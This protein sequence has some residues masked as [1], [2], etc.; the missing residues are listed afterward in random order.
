MKSAHVVIEGV[1]QGVNYRA[2]TQRAAAELELTGWVR[3]RLDGTVEALFCGE[4]ELVDRMVARCWEGPAPARVTN[5][6]LLPFS[7]EAPPPPFEVL[8]TV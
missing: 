5:V 4:T 2:W 3:N 1:V 7:G 8:P 6:R